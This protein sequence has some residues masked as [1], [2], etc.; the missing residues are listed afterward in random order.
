MISASHMNSHMYV[1]RFDQATWF[2]MQSLGVTPTTMRQ[3]HRRIAIVRQQYQFVEELHG[4]ELVVIKSG[5]VAVG[6]KYLRFLHQMFNI[7]TDRLVASSDCTAVQASLDIGK[8][9]SLPREL[10]VQAK[11]HLVTTNSDLPTP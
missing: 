4:G 1:S 6:E 2:L 5:F 7:E 10:Q 11:S 3:Q 9:I 8:S